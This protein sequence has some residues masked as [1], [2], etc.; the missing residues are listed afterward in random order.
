M[1]VI[2]GPARCEQLH[3]FIPCDA[4]QVLDQPVQIANHGR[5]MLGAEDNMNEIK[6][7]GVCH[8]TTLGMCWRARR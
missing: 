2:L 6:R 8:N 7:V 4:A 5:T 3:V 1:N